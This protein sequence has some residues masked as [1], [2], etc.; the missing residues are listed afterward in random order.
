MS[1]LYYE[2]RFLPPQIELDQITLSASTRLRHLDPYH[3]LRKQAKRI[4][5]TGR[6][7]SRFARRVLALPKSEQINPI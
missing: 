5:R 6:P 4:A 1:I 2:S 7:T 3:P